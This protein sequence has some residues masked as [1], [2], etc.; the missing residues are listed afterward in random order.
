[1]ISILFI[2]IAA[3]LNACMDVTKHKF[4]ISIFPPTEWFES[5]NWKSK[6]IGNNPSNG[7]RK[8]LG[9]I[10]EPSFM[11][12]GWHFYKYFMVVSFVLAVVLY[13][14]IIVW[15]ADAFIFCMTFPTIFLF[16]YKWGL[17]KTKYWY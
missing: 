11:Y 10:P 1:M 2:A 3:F 6:Y 9:F 7:R 12:D 14:P 17:I 5:E 4:Y 8:W 15:W 13:T 16:F